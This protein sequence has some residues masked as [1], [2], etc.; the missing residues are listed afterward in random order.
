MCSNRSSGQRTTRETRAPAPWLQPGWGWPSRPA[1]PRRTVGRSARDGARPGSVFLLAASSRSQRRIAGRAGC[2][3]LVINRSLSAPPQRA[4]RWVCQAA[5][6][7]SRG[8]RER[9]TMSRWTRAVTAVAAVLLVATGTLRWPA[10]G[11]SHRRRPAGPPG[12]PAV[13]GAACGTVLARQLGPLVQKGTITSD[14]EKAVVTA[15]ATM[16][17]SRMQGGQPPTKAAS[18]PTRRS[19][20]RHPVVSSNCRSAAR[21]SRACWRRW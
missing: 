1:S 7:M 18:H 16:I 12:V 3:R 19:V 20:P 8:I 6:F 9:C 11:G 15:F 4:P 21:C 17:A 5:S 13:S 2:G 10:A 14:Q